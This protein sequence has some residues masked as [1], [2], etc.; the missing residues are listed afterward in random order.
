M[1]RGGRFVQNASNFYTVAQLWTLA[2][3]LP[4]VRYMGD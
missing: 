4:T 1:T 3:V 2:L